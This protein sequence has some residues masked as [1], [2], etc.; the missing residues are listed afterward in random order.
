MSVKSKSHHGPII[1]QINAACI[2]HYAKNE[3][4]QK[5]IDAQLSVFDYSFFHLILLEFATQWQSVYRY[6]QRNC[7]SG[8]FSF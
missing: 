4:V 5:E 2:Q 3:N 1:N 6:V 8:S 7:T